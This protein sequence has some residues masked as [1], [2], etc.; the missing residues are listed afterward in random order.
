MRVTHSTECSAAARTTNAR[1]PPFQ[2]APTLT[3]TPSTRRLA[4]VAQRRATLTTVSSATLDK[5]IAAKNAPPAV[6]KVR[7]VWRP[8][9]PL[10]TVRSA[11]AVMQ[12]VQTPRVSSATILS[13]FAQQAHSARRLTAPL[14]TVLGAF[15]VLQLVQ[16]RMVSSVLAFLHSTGV[17][18]RALLV[19]TETLIHQVCVRRVQLVSTLMTQVI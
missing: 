11:F 9:A 5:I 4:Y 13:A 16:L 8:T 1:P 6:G 15:V 14:A 10:P 19:S 3:G 17:P 18:K 7:S 12:V 2:C